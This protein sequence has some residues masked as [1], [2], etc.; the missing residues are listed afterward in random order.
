MMMTFLCVN[1]FAFP[2]LYNP[3][4]LRLVRRLADP[5]R[6]RGVR[7]PSQR[8]RAASCESSAMGL[9]LSISSDVVRPP[10]KRTWMAMRSALTKCY[11]FNEQCDHAL[12]LDR[13]DCVGH[14]KRGGK[15]SASARILGHAHRLLNNLADRPVA[16]VV[17]APGCNASSYAQTFIPVR[18][19]R[20]GDKPVRWID[21]HISTA[22]KFSIVARSNQ[23]I[24][25]AVPLACS[26]RPPISHLRPLARLRAQPARRCPAATCLIA[27]SMARPRTDW[28]GLPARRTG[29]SVHM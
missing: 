14:S 16:E 23:L 25:H 17:R 18:F 3:S 24:L 26:T 20:V 7:R 1:D 6:F 19:Q 27:S 11:V 13:H 28:H 21:T 22:R 15:S 29:L 4:A 9:G 8:L 5:S 2:V 10:R 12:A